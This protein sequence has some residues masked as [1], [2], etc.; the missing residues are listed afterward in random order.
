MY[1]LYNKILIVDFWDNVM[2]LHLH[3]MD[4]A[5]FKEVEALAPEEKLNFLNRPS[6]LHGIGT[7]WWMLHFD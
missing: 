5:N 6:I 2:V 4:M 1:I 7:L 3:T